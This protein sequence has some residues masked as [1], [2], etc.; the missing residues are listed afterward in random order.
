MHEVGVA[1][2]II[3]SARAEVSS[4][5]GSKLVRVGVRVGVLSG[6]DCDALRFAF[7]ALTRGTEIE[8]TELEL[9]VCPRRNLCRQCGCEYN[10]ELYAS[11]CP[12]CS[13][14]AAELVSG[15]ELELAYVELE[16]P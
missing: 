8:Q 6:V 2:S 12:E 9:Q 5:P 15:E 16:E 11:P 7:Q 1:S 14:G 13:A 3:E 4:R 10:S